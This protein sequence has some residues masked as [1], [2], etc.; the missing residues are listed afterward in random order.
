MTYKLC[1]KLIELNKITA[2]MLDVYYAAGRLTDEQY[3]ELTA[4]LK[5]E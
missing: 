1:I 5:E 2:N 4:L 3:V